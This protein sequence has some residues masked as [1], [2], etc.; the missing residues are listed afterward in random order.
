MDTKGDYYCGGGDTCN[1]RGI[2]VFWDFE[3]GGDFVGG[4][5]L[6]FVEVI[7]WKFARCVV[8][9]VLGDGGM[10]FFWE[11]FVVFKRISE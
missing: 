11:L 6:G 2:R 1:C 3:V 7:G 8:G 9:E 4:D 5:V 10:D